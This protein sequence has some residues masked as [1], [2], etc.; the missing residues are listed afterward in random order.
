MD[1]INSIV[2]EPTFNNHSTG[3]LYDVKNDETLETAPG[4]LHNSLHR[5]N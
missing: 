2:L 5:S 4:N 1:L 3:L